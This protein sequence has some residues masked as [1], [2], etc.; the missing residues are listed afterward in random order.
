MYTLITCMP[1]I[2]NDTG[3]TERK[4]RLQTKRTN[5]KRE[6]RY[7]SRLLPLIKAGATTGDRDRCTGFI[8]K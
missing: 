3:E 8:N 4:K 1:H 2:A 5:E 6:L 7:K